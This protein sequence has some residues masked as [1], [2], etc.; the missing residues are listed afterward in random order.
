MASIYADSTTPAVLEQDEGGDF[1]FGVRFSSDRD[2]WATGVRFYRGSALNVGPHYGHV[3]DED[4]TLLGSTEPFDLSEPLGWQQAALTLPV[5]LKANRLY[6]VSYGVPDCHISCSLNTPPAATVGGL[7]VVGYC[8]SEV[9]DQFPASAS[10]NNYYADLVFSAEP[11]RVPVQWQWVAPSVPATGSGE[12][13]VDAVVTPQGPVAL[14]YTAPPGWTFWFTDLYFSSKH[15]ANYDGLERNCYQHLFGF[16][17]MVTLTELGNH[18]H[19]QTPMRATEPVRIGYQ[20]SSREPQ[21]MSGW[22]TGYLA[23]AGAL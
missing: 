10:T 1:E 13:A 18:V 23:P 8:Y 4:G 16:G 22:L 9:Q 15:I 21:N 12:A 2:G 20:N 3:W 6:V 5:R 11:P 17:F 14:P 19:L 7:S